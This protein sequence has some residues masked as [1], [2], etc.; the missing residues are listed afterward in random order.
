MVLDGFVI[1]HNAKRI[2]PKE[3]L[4]NVSYKLHRVLNNLRNLLFKNQKASVSKE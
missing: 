2:D 1:L 3:S 4:S